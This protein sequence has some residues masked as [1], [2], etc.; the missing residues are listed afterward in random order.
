MKKTLSILIL[1]I[2]F[3]TCIFAVFEFISFKRYENLYKEKFN[4]SN[5]LQKKELNTNKYK[6]SIKM[7]PYDFDDEAKN[8]RPALTKSTNGRPIVIFGCSFA[9]GDGLNDNQ[10][11]NYKLYKLTKRPVYNLAYRGWGAQQM[12]Y[13]LKGDGLYK[14]ITNP[15]YFIYVYMFDH[16]RRLSQPQ[17]Y[18]SSGT[19]YLRYKIEN[20]NLKEIKPFLYKTWGLYSVR[21]FQELYEKY[22][23]LKPINEKN[24][25]KLL[26]AIIEESNTMTKKR[27]PDSKFIVILYQDNNSISQSEKETWKDIAKSGIIVIPAEELLKD[28]PKSLEYKISDGHPNEKAWDIITSNLIKKIKN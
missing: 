24:N 19:P 8:F 1:N 10:T 5:A 17:W 18:Y 15:E 25:L 28:N 11:I 21:Y 16:R 23:T 9:Y 7:L 6:Y 2:I 22:V 26:K 3:I 14:K 20:G 12:L 27:Y 13:Q 4:K